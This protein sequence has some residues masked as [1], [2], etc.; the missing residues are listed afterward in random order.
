[1]QLDVRSVVI[2]NEI[3]ED[4]SKIDEKKGCAVTKGEKNYSTLH[5]IFTQELNELNH[6]SVVQCL[7]VRALFLRQ[8]SGGN[9]W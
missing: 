2:E 9:W 6:T 1:M 7:N 8:Y 3:Q 5:I 4:D